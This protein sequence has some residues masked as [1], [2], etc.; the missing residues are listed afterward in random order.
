VCDKYE[1]AEQTIHLGWR[2]NTCVLNVQHCNRNRR[3]IEIC[4]CCSAVHPVAVPYI[5]EAGDVCNIH[6]YVC[7]FIYEGT[8][9]CK[10]V[11][12]CVCIYALLCTTS[13]AGAQNP[14]FYISKHITHALDRSFFAKEPLI[15]GLFC[16]K[17]AMKRVCNRISDTGWWR[18]IGCL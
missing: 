11:C 16:G 1:W 4:H 10:Y 5:S 9:P 7:I 14:I 15:I 12:M 6:M 17:W 8:Y 18:C 2:F 13:G 3:N